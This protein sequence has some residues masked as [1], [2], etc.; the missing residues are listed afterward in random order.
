M[1]QL[2]ECPFFS[3]YHSTLVVGPTARSQD[4]WNGQLRPLVPP[5]PTPH[6]TPT[7]PW[8]PPPTTPSNKKCWKTGPLSI[9][10]LGYCFAAPPP[11]STPSQ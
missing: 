3:T 5:P 1:A 10:L 9:E 11:L 2:A 6:P 4:H 8:H 7:T